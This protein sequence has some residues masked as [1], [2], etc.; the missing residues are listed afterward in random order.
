[1]RDPAQEVETVRS[2]ITLLRDLIDRALDRGAGPQSP[3]LRA[4]ADL[5]HRRKNRLLE[6]EAITLYR[7]KGGDAA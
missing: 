6:L 4:C 5:L 3:Y 7:F 1:M 2:D